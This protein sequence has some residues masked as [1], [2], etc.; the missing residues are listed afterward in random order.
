MAVPTA[1]FAQAYKLRSRL[2]TEEVFAR[3]VGLPYGTRASAYCLHDWP[4]TP[5]A[6]RRVEAIARVLGFTGPTHTLAAE[7]APSAAHGR[8]TE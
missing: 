1:E 4:A 2:L 8:S 7:I 6:M 5:R 3:A